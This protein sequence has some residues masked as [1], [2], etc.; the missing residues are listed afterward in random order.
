MFIFKLIDKD[1]QKSDTKKED[2]SWH[3]FINHKMIMQVINHKI[4]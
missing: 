3:I 4:Y 1:G 2:K